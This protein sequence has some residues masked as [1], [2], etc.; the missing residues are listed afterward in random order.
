MQ[1]SKM[2]EK[3]ERLRRYCTSSK[4]LEKQNR[5]V[6]VKMLDIGWVFADQGSFRELIVALNDSPY[7]AIFST[8]LVVTLTKIF[9]KKYKS[10]IWWR[11]FIPYMVYFLCT[12]YFYTVITSPGIHS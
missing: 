8:N 1:I 11:C 10:A 9:D 3:K 2:I 12:I 5:K 7:E 4:K 6:N